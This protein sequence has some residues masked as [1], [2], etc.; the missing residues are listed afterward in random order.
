MYVYILA[1]LG[2]WVQKIEHPTNRS[3][4]N[5]HLFLL[6]RSIYLQSSCY[7]KMKTIRIHVLDF[8]GGPVIKNALADARDMSSI[9]GLGRFQMLQGN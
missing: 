6:A 8:P 4:N 1:Y 9:P 7:R 2:I 3:L 5:K